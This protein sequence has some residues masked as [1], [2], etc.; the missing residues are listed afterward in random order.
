MQSM[1]LE[2]T[3]N[4]VEASLEVDN[5]SIAVAAFHRGW[6]KARLSPLDNIIWS[7]PPSCR[8]AHSELCLWACGSRRRWLSRIFL[9]CSL[10][11]RPP[12]TVSLQPKKLRAEMCLSGCLYNRSSAVSLG[13]TCEAFAWTKKAARFSNRSSP[14]YKLFIGASMAFQTKGQ[15]N[16]NAVNIDVYSH[17]IRE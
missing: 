16:R 9:F 13:V 8:Q 12:S 5:D 6:P 15:T 17:K 7:R 3:K 11:N 14:M 2:L 4:D 1:C 10:R